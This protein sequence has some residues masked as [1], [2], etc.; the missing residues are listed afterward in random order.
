MNNIPNECDI[1]KYLKVE[2]EGYTL[3]SCLNLFKEYLG[4]EDKSA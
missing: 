4:I 2:S 3:Q 1:I